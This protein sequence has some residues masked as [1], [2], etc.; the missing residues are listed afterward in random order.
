MSPAPL[1]F[2]IRFGRIYRVFSSAFLL[3]PEDSYVEVEGYAAHVKMGWGFSAT[4]P[5]SA[6]ISAKRHDGRPMSRGIHGFAGKWLVNGSGDGI[7]VI[8]LDPT[9]K[10]RVLGIPVKLR[11]LAVTVDE[12]DALAERRRGR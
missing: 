5:L 2:P 8:D 11:Q 10:A 12:P 7:L 1:R 9:Q 6:V 3:S 4:F